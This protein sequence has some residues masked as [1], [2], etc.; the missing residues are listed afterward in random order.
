M[1][2]KKIELKDIPLNAIYEGYIWWSD[3]D[4]PVVLFDEQIPVTW[5]LANQLPV[6]IEGY[7]FC[8]VNQTSYSIRFLDEGYM[9]TKY[10]IDKTENG[11]IV[12]FIPNRLKGV[13]KIKFLQHWEVEKDPLCAGFE[14]LKPKANVFVGFEL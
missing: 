10:E 14:V 3:K 5:P 11:E 6:I 1:T 9:V 12:D 2:I 7:I 8:K 4:A 13:A